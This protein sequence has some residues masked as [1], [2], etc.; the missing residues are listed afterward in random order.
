MENALAPDLV[1]SAAAD[2][3]SLANVVIRRSGHAIK[4]CL[5]NIATV[6]TGHPI[7]EGRGPVTPV[8]LRTREPMTDLGFFGASFASGFVIFFGMIV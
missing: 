4:A 2:E 7:R 5:A 1:R 6:P 8:A 3:A